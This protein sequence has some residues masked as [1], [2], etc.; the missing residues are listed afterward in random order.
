MKKIKT[1]IAFRKYF[2]T[3]KLTIMVALATDKDCRY[4]FRIYIK[5]HP[6]HNWSIFV[7]GGDWLHDRVKAEQEVM[8]I[9]HS[10]F[11]KHNPIEINYSEN[12]NLVFG[13]SF[14]DEI[15]M[16][17]DIIECLQKNFPG[18]QFGFN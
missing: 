18:I 3:D 6:T 14:K 13:G 16:K 9:F 10:E 15:T 17:E 11:D 2:K 1:W 12:N 5:D 7:G 4:N 8:E